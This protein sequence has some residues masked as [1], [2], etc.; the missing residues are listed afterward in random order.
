M[1][2]PN[3]KCGQTIL[4]PD[5]RRKPAAAGTATKPKPRPAEEQLESADLEPAAS[6]RPT[7]TRKK[8]T[9]RGISPQTTAAVAV[10]ALAV[11]GGVGYGVYK[12]AFNRPN[13]RLAAGE[14]DL[15][16]TAPGTNP[17]DRPRPPPTGWVEY[18]SDRDKFKMLMGTPVQ[19]KSGVPRDYSVLDANGM[20]A[21]VSV[22]DLPAELPPELRSAFA[23]GLYRTYRDDP[24]SK[25][26]QRRQVPFVG[27]SATEL[28]FETARG[29]VPLNE[30]IR[31]LPLEKKRITITLAGPQ[32]TFG[33]AE[34]RAIFDTFALF[35]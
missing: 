35:E 4:V 22:H 26:V 19:I 27:R 32:S 5:P 33:P 9:A 23:D 10:A 20:Y 25:N 21:E 17:P 11:L 29:Q 24:L 12:L 31:I 13:A 7:R 34:A 28:S 18:R 3:P 14:R 8:R 15:T 6:G 2:C 16:G 1:T 30:Y